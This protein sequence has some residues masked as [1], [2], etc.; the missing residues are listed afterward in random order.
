M[1]KR[2]ERLKVL[3]LGS[4]V[5]PAY[6]GMILAEQGHSVE[7]WTT[8]DPI[9]SLDHGEKLWSWLN[10][11][12]HVRH[13]DAASVVELSASDFD[14]VIDNTR[15][16]TWKRR[17]IDVSALAER[18]DVVWVS[19]VADD[20]E[21][22][23]DVIAQAR[24]W[25]DFGILPFYLGD[26]AAGLWL[27]FKAL[28]ARV[29]YHEVGH[30]TCLAKLVEGEATFARPSGRYPFD[31]AEMYGHDDEGAFVEFKGERIVEPYRDDSWRLA[32]LK[33]DEGRFIV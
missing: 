23:F 21:R 2:A 12:K 7:K 22:S 30:A 33:N 19:L 1:L 31:D 16:S 29:G 25:G 6:A 32:N 4:Y 9:H 3:E 20:G 15:P 11:A 14:I 28:S 8:D 27:A 18:L 26:T 5:A 10:D 24:A 13:V 17:G